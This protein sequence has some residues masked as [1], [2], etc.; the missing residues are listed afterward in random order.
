MN[1]WMDCHT[2]WSLLTTGEFTNLLDST[3]LCHIFVAHLKEREEISCLI[4][5]VQ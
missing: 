1:F 4:K 5:S 3:C 2:H